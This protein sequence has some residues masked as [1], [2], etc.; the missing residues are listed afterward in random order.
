MKKKRKFLLSTAA[1]RRGIV[2]MIAL[3]V[4]VY[5]GI[6]IFNILSEEQMVRRESGQ[7]MNI[8]TG[9]NTQNNNNDED[10]D[11]PIILSDKTFEELRAINPNVV[12]W[13]SFHSGIINEPIVQWRDNERYLTRS[14]FGERSSMGTVFMDAYQNLNGNNITLYGHLVYNNA[15]MKFSPLQRLTDQANFERNRFFTFSTATEVRTFEVAIVFHYHLE[16]DIAI[17]FF[18]GDLSPELFMQYVNLARENQFYDTGV[19]LFPG[20]N[21]MTLQTCV[22]SR[23]YLRLIVVG[24]EISRVPTTN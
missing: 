7:L 10:V 6:Q 1:A 19:E 20:M 3:I 18:L 8:V 23:D 12:G 9:G 5:S 13:L 21:L 15:N 14:F 22:R 11:E 4:L 24:R 16:Y 17:P 2:M